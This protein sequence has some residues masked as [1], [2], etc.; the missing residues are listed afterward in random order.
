MKANCFWSQ[1]TSRTYTCYHLLVIRS[2]CWTPLFHCSMVILIAS[3]PRNLSW[4]TTRRS[5]KALTVGVAE[6][7]CNRQDQL[8][9]G[10]W[11][12]AEKNAATM[13]H[14][15]SLHC[16]QQFVFAFFAVSSI[17]DYPFARTTLVF[18][19]IV[20]LKTSQLG[21]ERFDVSWAQEIDCRLMFFTSTRP[22]GMPVHHNKR[23]APYI[24]LLFRSTQQRPWSGN[25]C[26]YWL[27]PS[28]LPT[29]DPA[30]SFLNSKYK[31]RGALLL[32]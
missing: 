15:R 24:Q 7:C 17:L 20:D 12:V 22:T 14:Q 16:H 3:K 6:I 31:K 9:L 26:N 21:F 19:K 18:A 5:P 4:Y 28:I 11:L 29:C 32:L 25:A 1:I 10:L 23:T 30:N 8:G 13:H 27:R 2:R